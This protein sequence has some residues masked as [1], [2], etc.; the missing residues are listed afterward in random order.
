MKINKT[1][2]ILV[3][4]E[5]SCVIEHTTKI[6]EVF[7]KRGYDVIANMGMLGKKCDEWGIYNYNIIKDSKEI[8]IGTV[9]RR[10]GAISNVSTYIEIYETPHGENIEEGYCGFLNRIERIKIT[11]DSGERAI[12]NKINKILEK[13]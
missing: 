9:W 10:N 11:K 1:R 12:N 7:E 13:F 4:P 2:C 6:A 5:E 8:K 3:Y